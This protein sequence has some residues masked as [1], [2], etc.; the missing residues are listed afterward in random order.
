MNVKKLYNLKSF[1]AV[2][3]H[4]FKDSATGLTLSKNLTAIDPKIFEAKYPDL[5]FMNSGIEVDNTGGITAN[6][7]QSL[8]IS[9][10]GGFRDAG[11]QGSAGIISIAGDFS[12][13]RVYKRQGTS[14]WDED[15]VRTAQEQ[16]FSLLNRLAEAQNKLYLRDLDAIGYIGRGNTKGLL[17]YS[18]FNTTV[19]TGAIGTLTA[20]EMY[21]VIQAQISDQNTRNNNTAG[22]MVSRADLTVEVFNTINKTILNTASGSSTVLK[23]LR[24]NNPDV[25]FSANHRCSDVGG[26][27]VCAFYG[28]T[29]EGML[30]RVPR[31]LE[32]GAPF[33]KGSY[34]WEIESRYN[35]AGLDVLDNAIANL[36]IGL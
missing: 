2:A 5:M 30:M 25:T 14:K 16:G 7:I 22:F 34:K 28:T 24:D 35:V 1:D 13:I 15:D 32:V 20:K 3:A 17:N 4:N 11:D 26:N 6:T 10:Q 33:Q 27:T 8:R 36:L 29:R 21:D 12:E 18:D 23:A 19:A 9:D 31:P